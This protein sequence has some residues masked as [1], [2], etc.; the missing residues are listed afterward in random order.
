[1]HARQILAKGEE[2]TSSRGPHHRL[3]TP[4][5]LLAQP[6]DIVSTQADASWVHHLHEDTLLITIEITNSLIHQ[7]LV[8]SE[9]AFNILYWDTYQK[10]GLRRADLTPTTSHFYGF[11]EDSVIP[12][13]TIKLAVTLG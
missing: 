6:D 3:Q 5:G 10:I 12:K 1:M 7:L 13:G 9:S 4:K 11:A 8:D 2:N